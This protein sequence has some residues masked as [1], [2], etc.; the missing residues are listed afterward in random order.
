MFIYY[1][2]CLQ[3]PSLFLSF[4]PLTLLFPS[5]VFLPLFPS[6]LTFFPPWLQ[7]C[8]LSVWPGT[9]LGAKDTEGPDPT[10]P[11]QSSPPGGEAPPPD[12]LRAASSDTPDIHPVPLPHPEPESRGTEYLQLWRTAGC[13]RPRSPG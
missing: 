10:P 3:F 4:L 6:F 9:V 2:A 11:V 1:L 12:L 13:R 7:A 8:V 5:C